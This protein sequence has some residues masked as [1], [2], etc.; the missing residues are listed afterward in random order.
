[1]IEFYLDEKQILLYTGAIILAASIF[2]HFKWRKYHL[3]LLALAAIFLGFWAIQLNDYLGFWD[4]Q[5]HA[6]V[7]KNCIENPL[8]PTLYKTVLTDY[9]YKNWVG[10]H[11]WLHKQPWFLWQM[12]LSMKIFGV[13]TVALRLPNLIMFVTLIFL[14][15]GIGKNLTSAKVGYYMGVLAVF[16][17]VLLELTA[18]QLHTDHNDVAAVFYITASIWSWSHYQKSKQ[19]KW[20]LLMGLFAGIAVLNKSLVGMMVF[21]LFFFSMDFKFKKSWYTLIGAGIIS[22]AVFM[23]WELFIK[24][25]Y[26]LESAFESTTRFKHITEVIEGHKESWYYYF[27]Q[28]FKHY[29]IFGFALLALP[30]MFIAVFLSNL[31]TKP[32]GAIF[33]IIALVLTFYTI[34]QTKMPVF[35]FILAPFFFYFMALTLDRIDAL[36]R[37]KVVFGIILFVFLFLGFQHHMIYQ[38]HQPNDFRNARTARALWYANNANKWSGK[39]IVYNVPKF[40]H[41]TVMF[42]TDAVA[43]PW[44]P[45]EEDLKKAA[46]NGYTIYKFIGLEKDEVQYKKVEIP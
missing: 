10:N 18:G 39:T 24:Q 40:E 46:E 13:N 23:P 11:V 41:N 6:N 34:A 7:A 27:E 22:L 25:A 19:L 17:F 3:G 45:K 1:M 15:Y 21:G 29:S 4:E 14:L 37:N 20:A 2:S 31:N 9:D 32:K 43:Y 35:T 33:L 44:K 16:N 30:G 5:V 26:P 38:A 8:K 28:L 36:I 12:A 42:F